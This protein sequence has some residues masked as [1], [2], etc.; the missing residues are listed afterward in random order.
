MTTT[1]FS[2]IETADAWRVQIDGQPLGRFERE[3][4][5]VRCAAGLAADVQG[6]GGRIE[7]LVQDRTGEITV[8]DSDEAGRSRSGAL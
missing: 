1:R 3:V 7:L 8:I 2:V 6:S 4:D 5:A